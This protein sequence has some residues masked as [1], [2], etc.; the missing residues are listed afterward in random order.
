MT[1]ADTLL[2]ARALIED[3][4]RW[5]KGCLARDEHGDEVDPTDG[6]A[7]SFCALG[8]LRSVATDP[9]VFSPAYSCLSTA[10]DGYLVRTNNSGTHADALALFNKAV[11][12]ALTKEPATTVP[13][14]AMS[15]RGASVSSGA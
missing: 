4:N 12:L 1:T 15:P 10:A 5:L 8:A 11:G 2:A 7:V 3:R 13:Q 14:H 6:N 9:D